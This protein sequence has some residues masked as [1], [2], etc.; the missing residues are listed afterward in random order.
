MAGFFAYQF[1]AL[2]KHGTKRSSRPVILAEAEI[3]SVF[4]VLV[5]RFHGNDGIFQTDNGS[6]PKS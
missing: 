1:N 6:L 4:F 3:R 5:S 2:K